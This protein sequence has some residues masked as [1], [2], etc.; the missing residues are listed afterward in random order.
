MQVHVVSGV[1][2][3]I[4]FPEGQTKKKIFFPLFV[5][6]AVLPL[7]AT[8]NLD[9]A[10]FVR[11]SVH[12]GQTPHFYVQAAYTISSNLEKKKMGPLFSSSLNK[13]KK[14]LASPPK[15]SSKQSKSRQ[16]Q[17]QGIM[18]TKNL[19]RGHCKEAVRALHKLNPSAERQALELLTQKVL[20]RLK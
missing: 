17:S 8:R 3:R 18:E 14:E 1:Q 7:S 19:A 10:M 5:S 12:R 2:E 4:I 11:P 15:M 20:N 9:S 16:F 13:E 6:R